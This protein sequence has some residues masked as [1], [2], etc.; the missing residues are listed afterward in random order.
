[1]NITVFLCLQCFDT[2]GWVKKGHLACKKLSGRDAGMVVCLGQGA[3]LHTAH[4]MPLPITIS[5]SSKS[6]MVLPFW[7][8]LSRVVPDRIQQG[9]KTVVRVCDMVSVDGDADAAVEA[10]I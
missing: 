9:R 7:C 3:N 1:M 4:L 5:C 10:R 6:R 2:V 8:Q